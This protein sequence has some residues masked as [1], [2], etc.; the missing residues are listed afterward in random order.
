MFW[1]W[2]TSIIAQL[3]DLSPLR[4][5]FARHCRKATLGR[6]PGDC[7]HGESRWW[8][9]HLKRGHRFWFQSSQ[10]CQYDSALPSDLGL[11]LN[12]D[13]HS[14]FLKLGSQPPTTKLLVQHVLKALRLTC[15]SFGP[16]LNWSG[17]WWLRYCIYWDTALNGFF[18]VILLPMVDIAL[19][20][21]SSHNR[22][23]VMCSPL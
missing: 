2:F 16:R 7:Q 3:V 15:H 11:K 1:R 4:R 6:R 5:F 23:E 12:V 10:I 14:Y 20:L 19:V 8:F 13:W 9:E 17:Y 22:T 18:C 21:C